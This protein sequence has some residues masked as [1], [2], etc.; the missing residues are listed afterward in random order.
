MT[1]SLSWLLLFRPDHKKTYLG[2]T[3]INF[4]HPSK[5]REKINSRESLCL[6]FCTA[7]AFRFIFRSILSFFR[8][9]EFEGGRFSRQRTMWTGLS[10]QSL[11]FL[12]SEIWV[13]LGLIWKYIVNSNCQV[14]ILRNS[15]ENIHH[16]A[17]FHYTCTNK[18]ADLLL[19]LAEFYLVVTFSSQRHVYGRL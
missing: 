15:E 8:S 19:V 10:A 13:R 17:I 6:L 5:N 1:Y 14:L 2:K 7:A 12:H 4:Q 3:A 16:K 9:T 18:A 11:F